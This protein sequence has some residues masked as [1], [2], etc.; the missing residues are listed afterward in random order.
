[1]MGPGYLPGDI[2]VPA[3]CGIHSWWL[4]PGCRLDGGLPERSSQYGIAGRSGVQPGG[5]VPGHK[6]REGL[7]GPFSWGG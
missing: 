1:M 6:P 7:W 3:L 4:V 2:V 5:S